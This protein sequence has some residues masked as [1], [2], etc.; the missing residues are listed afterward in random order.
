MT[1]ISTGLSNEVIGGPNA[2][3]GG[4]RFRAAHSSPLAA[5]RCYDI[6]HAPGYSGGT[7]GSILA[8]LFTDVNGAPGTIELARA[9][10][11]PDVEFPDPLSGRGRF[12]LLFFTPQWATQKG[13]C[14]WIV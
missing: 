10:K 3:Q 6:D 2:I 14:Y 8:R 4:I 12:P 9:V 1:I 7:G 13:A 11:V 5:F